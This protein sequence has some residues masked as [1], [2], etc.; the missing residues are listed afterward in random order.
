MVVIGQEKHYN[1]NVCRD[2][3]VIPEGLRESR[4]EA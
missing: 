1:R 4:K 3:L 2:L